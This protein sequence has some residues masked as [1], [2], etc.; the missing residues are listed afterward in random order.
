MGEAL[1]LNT[2]TGKIL[3]TILRAG[4]VLYVS[5][6][7]EGT[8][9]GNRNGIPA[10]D[11]SSY[12]LIGWDFVLNPG[13]L[14][15]NPS[16]AEALEEIQ[17]SEN[18][19]GDKPMEKVLERLNNELVD[20]KSK[21]ETTLTEKRSL[22]E[23]VTAL[24]EENNHV[25][26]ELTK[27]ESALTETEKELNTVKEELAQFKTLGESFDSVKKALTE[28]DAYISKVHEEL[29]TFDRVKKAL[30]TALKFKESV[31]AL[32]TLSEIEEGLKLAEQMVTE[33]EGRENEDRIAALAKELGVGGEAV[34]VLAAKGL[35]DD[36]IKALLKKVGESLAP[37]VEEKKEKKVEEKK[38]EKKNESLV[39]KDKEAKVIDEKKEE[40][41]SYATKSRLDRIMEG[42]S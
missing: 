25:K 30:E 35:Q 21:Y 17:N 14:K 32:G 33:A 6:R 42:L 38:T 7:G 29:G 4:S 20:V 34:A 40:K 27:A 3:N 28:S 41:P 24:S 22:S 12:N 13:F 31:D 9:E 2:P 39:K 18:K 5:S 37:K 36:E 16:I 8:F 23:S 1:I 15:A 10:V 19:E 11:E 26:A